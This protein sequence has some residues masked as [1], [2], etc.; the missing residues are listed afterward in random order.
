MDKRPLCSETVRH[1]FA[2]LAVSEKIFGFLSTNGSHLEI[3]RA[4]GQDEKSCH[5]VIKSFDFIQKY[6]Q[7]TSYVV[8]C[9]KPFILHRNLLSA[10]YIFL[11]I[12]SVDTLISFNKI[13]TAIVL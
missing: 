8:I 3:I 6:D 13:F 5:N 10:N 7:L 9:V 11:L 12:F 2:V 4:S 1:D